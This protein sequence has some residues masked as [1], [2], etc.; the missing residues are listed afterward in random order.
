MTTPDDVNSD[1]IGQFAAGRQSHPEPA[2][3]LVADGALEPELTLDGRAELWASGTYG[4]LGTEK[5]S[6]RIT[7]ILTK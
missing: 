6:E 3:E 4:K 5:P 7:E 1:K 2:S